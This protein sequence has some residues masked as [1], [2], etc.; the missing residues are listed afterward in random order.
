MWIYGGKEQSENTAVVYQET[1]TG[2]AEELRHTKSAFVYFIIEGSG[3]WVIEGEHF[4]VQASDAVIVPAVKKFYF[5]G[6]LKQVC[7]TATA[8]E[9]E[10]EET[11]GSADL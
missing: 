6:N 8:W 5:T 10:F 7:V 9:P 2:H 4:P 3:E 11:A 1:K